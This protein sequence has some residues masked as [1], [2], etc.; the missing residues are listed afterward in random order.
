MTESATAFSL[1]TGKFSKFL[2]AAQ[3]AQQPYKGHLEEKH[4]EDCPL[5]SC[6]FH[7]HELDAK[8]HVTGMTLQEY[9]DKK[10]RKH[11]K[12][13][14]HRHRTPWAVLEEAEQDTSNGNAQMEGGVEKKITS[15]ITALSANSDARKKRK[16]VVEAGSQVAKKQPKQQRGSG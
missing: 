8:C 12:E 6:E 16:L 9:A 4:F 15:H 2:V 5:D 1:V 13:E 3:R 7:V 10:E 11:R 14:R